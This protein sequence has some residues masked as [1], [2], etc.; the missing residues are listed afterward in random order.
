MPARRA[1]QALANEFGSSRI[2]S[3]RAP[4]SCALSRASSTTTISSG[5]AGVSSSNSGATD[6]R[7]AITIARSA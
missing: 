6:A 7:A 1:R 4:R 3:P 5:R 2:A